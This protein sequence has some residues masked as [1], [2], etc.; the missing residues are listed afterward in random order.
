[1][2]IL[3]FICLSLS[4]LS[5][6]LSEKPTKVVNAPQTI[7][8]TYY[9][10]NGQLSVK[11]GP[12][13]NQI[14]ETICYDRQGKE[15][16]RFEEIRHSYSVR[17]ELKFGKTGALSKV[18]LH[19]NPGASRTSQKSTMTFDIDNTPLW[20]TVEEIPSDANFLK[21]GP[22]KFYWNKSTREWTR[23]E[24]VFEQETPKQ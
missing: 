10:N 24:E 21:N 20:M 6:K 11:I 2:K 13:E 9:H 5:C 17:A 22:K 23:Q 12:W 16:Y 8:D 3:V 15:T 1:M 14:R 19:T 4:L 18:I 7:Q